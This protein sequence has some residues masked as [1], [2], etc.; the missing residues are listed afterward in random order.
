MLSA[1]EK[2]EGSSSMVGN[3][4]WTPETGGPYRDGKEPRARNKFRGRRQTEKCL[5]PNQLQF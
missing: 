5:F 3:A 4:H 2:D 1:T